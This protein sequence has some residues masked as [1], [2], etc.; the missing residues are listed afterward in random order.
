M[1]KKIISL[2]VVFCLVFFF[3]GCRRT[4]VAKSNDGVASDIKE[5]DPIEKS[6]TDTDKN[7]TTPYFIKAQ[8]GDIYVYALD[9]LGV[10]YRY[11]IFE[12]STEPILENISD[13]S[14][15]LSGNLFALQNDGS[16]QEYPYSNQVSG[17]HTIC[18]DAVAISNSVLILKDGSL[19]HHHF[20]YDSWNEINLKAKQ[21]SADFFQAAIID[22]DNTLW[23]Y[24]RSTEQLTKIAENVIDCDYYHF[25][26]NHYS[27]DLWYITKDG[28]LHL[29]EENK[30]NR[31]ENAAIPSTAISVAA[32]N[33]YY[34][35]QQE[36]STYIYGHYMSEKPKKKINIEGIY[37]DITDSTFAIID[38]QKQ[39]HLF[40]DFAESEIIID[41]Q[42]G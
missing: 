3:A 2:L 16:M 32:S 7:D 38:K 13:F 33:G 15:D 22:L 20:D 9:N 24:D 29:I 27:T 18:S 35:A 37:A 11:N 36:D 42:L 8:I 40:T 23:N 6:G 25:N 19:L 26:K 30:Q 12:A 28:S 31:E 17:C 39:L 41:H 4:I 1:Q 5:N 21:V 14:V 10:L 34:L